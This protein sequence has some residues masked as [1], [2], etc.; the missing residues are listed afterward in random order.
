MAARL[1][2]AYLLL[3]TALGVSY[4]AGRLTCPD[5]APT[6]RARTQ[7]P[8]AVRVAG[9]PIVKDAVGA[10]VVTVRIPCPSNKNRLCFITLPVTTTP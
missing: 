5:P 3:G 9:A 7:T 2:I 4:T 8:A 6:I 10:L 1:I